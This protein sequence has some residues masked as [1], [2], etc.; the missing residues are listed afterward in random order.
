MGQMR[1]NQGEGTSVEESP[2]S[3]WPVGICADLCEVSQLTVE[4]STSWQVG[5]FI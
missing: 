2:P 5:W 4:G 3:D 1:D